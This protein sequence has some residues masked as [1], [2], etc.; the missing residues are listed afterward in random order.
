[1]APAGAAEVFDLTVESAAHYISGEGI[2]HKNCYDELPQFSEKVY[3]RVNAWLRTTE[4]GQRCR[5][6]GA[7]NPP[8]NVEEEWV[9]KYWGPWLDDQHPEYP[10]PPGALRWFISLGDRDEQVE[11]GDPV[12]IPVRGRTMTV[13][14]TS[15]TFIPATLDDNPDLRDSGYREKLLSLH[16]PMRSQLLFGDMTIGR[17][18]DEQQVIPTDWV[19]RSMNRSRALGKRPSDR[20]TCSA[21][22]P[23]KG[24]AD[25]MALAKRYDR[26]I[27]PLW[28]WPGKAVT[29]ENMVELVR[30]RLDHLRSPLVIDV[31][32]NPGGTA[33]AS[34]KL[35]HKELPVVPVNFAS[36][37]TFRDR[38]GRLE[39][40]NL[41]A[42]AY[43]RMR[44]A[45]DPSM[46]PE[47]T[48]LV[49]P[50]DMELK[51]ELC[52]ARYKPNSKYVQLEPKEKIVERLGRSPDRADAAVMTLLSDRPA[53]GGW[54]NPVREAKPPQEQ[55]FRP[56]S[57]GRPGG[58]F[59]GVPG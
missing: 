51:T 52:M 19:M 39:M 42:E 33:V 18:D 25:N 27:D 15:R 5:V 22:D 28:V 55:A 48:R 7:G 23:A 34:F 37:S 35:K 57:Y 9:L 59:M 38:S 32:A 8:L 44:E 45:L 50:Y 40:A 26:W 47:E 13:R 10:A 56:V 24:G 1:M 17:S 49:L 31:G 12:Q 54:V 2:V 20:L 53:D 29:D 4:P 3:R 16:E 43:W 21:L 6:V 41:R 58:G 46:G 11:S 30:A 36:A 14:P